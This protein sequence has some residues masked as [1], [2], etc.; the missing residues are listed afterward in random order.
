[1]RMPDNISTALLSVYPDLVMDTG[2]LVRSEGGGRARLRP[3]QN[4]D[5]INPL[6]GLPTVEYMT[7][8]EGAAARKSAG[9]RPKTWNVP[10][11]PQMGD[12]CLSLYTHDRCPASFVF[13]KTVLETL[14]VGPIGCSLSNV[15]K[16]G[17]GPNSKRLKNRFRHLRP[18][19]TSTLFARQIVSLHS[20]SRHRENEAASGQDTHGQSWALS[21]FFN[22]FNNKNDFL[23]FL[24][25]LFDSEWAF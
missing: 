16:S 24:S 22:F 6:T 10:Q 18:G 25:S 4:L 8:V 11:I 7:N 12:L 19:Q 9:K 14:W 5:K 15:V 20:Q 13:L 2:T 23:H 17:L 1:M 21:V 3:Y